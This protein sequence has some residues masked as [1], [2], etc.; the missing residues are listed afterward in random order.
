[1]K[2]L[3]FFYLIILV[4][5]II[6]SG[7][8]SGLKEIVPV[9]GKNK[10]KKMLSNGTKRQD[11]VEELVKFHNRCIESISV[12][13]CFFI[14][15]SALVLTRL[16][17]GIHSNIYCFLTLAIIVFLI[18]VNLFQLFPIKIA[19]FKQ[20]KLAAPATPLITFIEKITY[21]WIHIFYISVSPLARLFGISN[22]KKEEE[23]ITEEDIKKMIDIG[24][25][26]GVIEAEDKEMIK[27][28]F[29]F[30]ETLTREVMVPRIDMICVEAGSKIE[31]IVA[32]SVKYGYSRIPVYEGNRDNIVGIVYIKDLVL[33][34]INP[35]KDK[36]LKDYMR[37]PYFVPGS[38]KLDDLLREMQ[39]KKSAIAIVV[40]EYGG[41]D[42][43]VTLEDLLEEIV[44]DIVDEHDKET[45]MIQ[46]ISDNSYSV[47]AKT[48]IEDANDELN[49]SIPY[50]EFETV[51]GY[52]YGLFDR[53][54]KEGE[55]KELPD[56]TVT[57][58][59]IHRQ[60]IKRVT[61]T[62]KEHTT[63]EKN[64]QE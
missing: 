53:I 27:S 1:M 33:S 42:G 7:I 24:E 18:Q 20:E 55:T 26:H 15:L 59:K 36:T 23:F 60:R 43:L 48:I 51:G 8:L 38:K 22:I 34:L 2:G 63:F 11:M 29:E 64:A 41:T 12:W 37:Q 56:F 4:F 39:G 25:D 40:D 58:E 31:E 6:L 10:I 3:E 28:I 14:F 47:D 13:N 45:P 5:S 50:D 54:P 49:I 62:I 17:S 30:G 21:F 9:V 44:G 46:Q 19:Q 61:I 35:D 52:V 32:T 16:V 57:I